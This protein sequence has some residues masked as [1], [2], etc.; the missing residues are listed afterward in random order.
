MDSLTLA[1]NP[2]HIYEAIRG[3]ISN[4][5]QF[6]DVNGEINIKIQEN[7]DQIVQLSISNSGEI[8]EAIKTQIYSSQS[9]I[10]KLP[11]KRFGGVGISLNLIRRIIHYY[12]GRIWIEVLPEPGTI[13]HINLP[14]AE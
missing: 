11:K 7:T 10:T 9:Q 8:P 2:N 12:S 4:A 13:F 14:V 3:L 1:A 5:I 6:C